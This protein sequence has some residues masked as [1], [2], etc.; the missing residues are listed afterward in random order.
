M[1]LAPESIPQHGRAKILQSE[2]K[3]PPREAASVELDS[4]GTTG[5]KV[6]LFAAVGGDKDAKANRAA[7][8]R[9][10]SVDA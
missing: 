3:R 5:L 7:M 10:R 8:L 2:M 6:T 4:K 1:D 9:A